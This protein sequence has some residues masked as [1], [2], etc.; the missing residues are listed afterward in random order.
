[1]VTDKCNTFYIDLTVQMEQSLPQQI[2][3]Q[4]SNEVQSLLCDLRLVKQEPT[5]SQLNVE[6]MTRTGS[7]R[8]NINAAVEIDLREKWR[9]FFASGD[10]QS[11]FGHR[12]ILKHCESRSRNRGAWWCNLKLMQRQIMETHKSAEMFCV[13]QKSIPIAMSNTA[14]CEVSLAY[15]ALLYTVLKWT[16]QNLWKG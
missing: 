2:I 8:R 9:K 13:V 5:R 12:C 15:F 7:R 16:F 14:I 4:L 1:M 6:L 11:S 3:T 10:R